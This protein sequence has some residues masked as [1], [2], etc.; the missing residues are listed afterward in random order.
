MLPV[1]SA[2]PHWL[3]LLASGP[4]SGSILVSLLREL[5]HQDHSLLSRPVFHNNNKFHSP[6]SAP[7]GQLVSVVTVTS[8]H[9]TTGQQ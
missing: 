6:V 8:P 2:L 4:G 5:E 7:T 1:H 3:A 9:D